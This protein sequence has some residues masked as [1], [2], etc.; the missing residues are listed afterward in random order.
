MIFKI[1]VTGQE[2]ERYLLY[3]RGEHILFYPFNLEKH[4]MKNK[5]WSITNE[6]KQFI[7]IEICKYLIKNQRYD[8]IVE[9]C[10]KIDK[11][12]IIKI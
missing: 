4:S 7:T 11:K 10:L 12:E 3:L 9:E 6:D 8:Y 1:N 2:I 5:Y